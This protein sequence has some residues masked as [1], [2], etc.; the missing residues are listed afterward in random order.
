[1]GAFYS[2]SCTTSAIGNDVYHALH[3]KNISVAA[4]RKLQTLVIF[5]DFKLVLTSL[6]LKLDCALFLMQIVFFMSNW[7]VLRQ[8]TKMGTCSHF[9]TFA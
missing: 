6:N 2:Q 3:M 1:M 4:L 9:L 8:L 7:H 5:N